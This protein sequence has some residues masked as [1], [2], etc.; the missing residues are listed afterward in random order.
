MNLPMNR[1]QGVLA[2]KAVT[3]SLSERHIGFVDFHF[4]ADLQDRVNSAREHFQ[5]LKSESKDA[6]V[7][8]VHS[9]EFK[10]TEQFLSE[11]VFWREGFYTLEVNIDGKKLKTPHQEFL[12]LN[13]TRRDIDEILMDLPV[14]KEEL[15]AQIS[16]ETI[17]P[18][19]WRLVHP[20]VFSTRG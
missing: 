13:V 5:Y 2:I 7:D 6:S 18:H 8:L 15:R 10:H 9:K 19:K 12:T 4:L 20:Q 1:P 3:E 11:N 14:V 16:G 17:T